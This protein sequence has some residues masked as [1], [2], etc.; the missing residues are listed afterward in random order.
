MLLS[1]YNFKQY[2]TR[3]NIEPHLSAW[4]LCAL[5]FAFLVFWTAPYIAP[6]VVTMKLPRAV[7]VSLKNPPSAF[8]VY[9]G[10]GFIF[11][12]KLYN[13][14]TLAQELEN[15]PQKKLLLL[16]AASNTSMQELL[17]VLD[18]LERLG[19]DEVAFTVKP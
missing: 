14:T 12:N 1:T 15:M 5:V 2:L 19:F 6:D 3:P 16:A 18:R 11:K 8:V 17:P 7:P 13:M 4:V 9:T 10:S